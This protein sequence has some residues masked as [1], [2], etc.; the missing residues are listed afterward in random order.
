MRALGGRA[1]H[2][3][4]RHM[5]ASVDRMQ[6][7]PD[8][9]SDPESA[10]PLLTRRDALRRGLLLGFG[11]ATVVAVSGCAGGGD[12]EDDEDD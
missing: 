11:M 7:N 8:A 5:L 10:F 4:Q 3:L 12:D 1:S 9:A 6:R 2:P